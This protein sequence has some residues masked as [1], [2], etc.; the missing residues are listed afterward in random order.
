MENPVLIR[1]L[2]RNTC[3]TATPI[4]TR[5]LLH[6]EKA[7]P[8]ILLRSRPT[9]R[10]ITRCRGWTRASCKMGVVYPGEPSQLA[11]QSS[12]TPSSTLSHRVSEGEEGAYSSVPLSGPMMDD[13]SPSH[14]H[15]SA[16]DQLLAAKDLGKTEPS[17]PQ[18]VPR[19][20][21]PSS[22]KTSWLIG[23]LEDQS[24]DLRMQ[25]R[26][27]TPSVVSGPRKKVERRS[28]QHVICR[29]TYS[30]DE[31]QWRLQATRLR[32]PMPP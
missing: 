14:P 31:E 15:S 25:D 21:S 8:K 11:E 4:P 23:S 13:R 29:R 24:D 26:R 30:T 12:A 9:T 5:K 6:L 10:S 17:R 18:D 27:R 2:P 32:K 3:K 28:Y 22:R 1:T 7:A 20:Q 16:M 19:T